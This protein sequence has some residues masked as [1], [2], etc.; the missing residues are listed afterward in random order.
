[1]ASR[2]V[3]DAVSALRIAD[4]GAGEIGEMLQRQRELSIQAGN[5]TLSDTDR[6]ALDI[7]FQQLTEE[8]QRIAGGTEFNRQEV[9]DGT[10]LASGDA[11]VQAGANAEDQLNLPQVDLTSATLGL[12]SLSIASASGASAAISSLDT[13][14]DSVNG[15][16]STIGA[17]MNRLTSAGN[18]LQVEEANMT[19]AQSA[20]AD[21]DMAAGLV[22][23]SR[24][25]LLQEGGIKA[26]QRFN[27]INANHILAL[28]R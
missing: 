20:I 18:N 13:A 24:Q 22:E 16:R 6:Q 5:A 25:Q 21:Q 9:A 15:Q 7:E 11:V 1:M 27:D 2:N 14:L 3:D 12:P 10:G 23:L 8:I 17:M 28:L 4:G 26:F 19:A